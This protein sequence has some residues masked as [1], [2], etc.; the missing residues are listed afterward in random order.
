MQITNTKFSS[1]FCAF[2]YS[3]IAYGVSPSLNS[4]RLNDYVTVQTLTHEPRWVDSLC[5]CPDLQN[6]TIKSE[7]KMHVWPPAPDDTISSM[8]IT[9]DRDI[10]YISGREGMYYVTSCL[11]PG[12]TRFYIKPEIYS[13]PDS[14]STHDY[15]TQGHISAI[16]EYKSLGV[17]SK[18]LISSLS[19]VLDE[20]DTLTN[21]EC[22]HTTRHGKIIFNDSDTCI[23]H[24]SNRDWFAPGYRYPILCETNDIIL[25]LSGDTIDV[26]K[27]WSVMSPVIQ[28]TD[29]KD[30]P[31]NEY[32]RALVKNESDKGYHQTF[33]VNQSDRQT[34]LHRNIKI[35]AD[36]G[37]IEISRQ[38]GDPQ[39][40][41]VVL[42]DLSGRV[43]FAKTWTIGQQTLTI[44]IRS[45][46]PGQYIL[47]VAAEGGPVICKFNLI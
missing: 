36:A 46:I 42:C 13:V 18:K 15:E 34:S 31:T 4:P 21:A 20:N 35:N 11:K 9:L 44:P 45:L 28:E 41:E 40:K 38:F 1:L 23:L 10:L 3:I 32:I 6:L 7:K 16:G 22:V 26:D 24:A 17:S 39:F 8:I 47:Y 27:S 33:E 30:D 25:S 43:Y 5:Y 19:I 29:L 37:E 12:I 2:A 14:F